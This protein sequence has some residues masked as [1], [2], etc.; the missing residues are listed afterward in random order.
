M[1]D[2]VHK[3]LGHSICHEVAWSRVSKTFSYE[4]ADLELYSLS[5]AKP[6]QKVKE[7]TWWKIEYG[8]FEAVSIIKDGLK[9]MPNLLKKDLYRP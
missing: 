5:N 2:F 4:E 7:E 9:L 1:N 6:V 3:S 8:S